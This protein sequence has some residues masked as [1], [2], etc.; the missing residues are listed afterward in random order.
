M[1]I[2]NIKIPSKYHFDIRMSIFDIQTVIVFLIIVKSL[3][4][5]VIIAWR[6]TH[7]PSVWL[8]FV[9]TELFAYETLMY[10]YLSRRAVTNA[11]RG[12]DLTL[13]M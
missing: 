4:P 6:K 13:L 1:T 10:S 7:I 2:S 3:L 9:C 8:V 12:R 11:L 5:G